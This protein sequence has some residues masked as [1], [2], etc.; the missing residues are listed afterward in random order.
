ME[1]VTQLK[2][3]G[4]SERESVVYLVLVEFG[5]ATV[6]AIAARARLSRPVV[7]KTLPSLT[8]RGLVVATKKGARTRFVAEP[9]EK[10]GGL[11]REMESALSL[12]LPKLK[13]RYESSN[14]RPVIKV[15]EGKRGI[16]F[17]FDDLVKTLPRGSVYY[18]YSSA[19]ASHD[20]YLPRHYRT[21]R[22]AKKLERYVITNREQ[23]DKKKP[24][25]ER[26]VRIV[27]DK[28]G[29]FDQ[30]ITQIV[31]GDKVAMIDYGSQTAFLVENVAYA[32]FQRRLFVALYDLLQP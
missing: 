8:S 3:L 2:Q 4:L 1:L 9:P 11:L 21:L 32:E 25:M 18:R 10:L 24:R 16:S 15:L 5:P 7:Y 27:S 31:Y 12:L 14:L 26:G 19:R 30:D 6:A 23:A 17:V 20:E 29:L 22:D 13:A 28:Y